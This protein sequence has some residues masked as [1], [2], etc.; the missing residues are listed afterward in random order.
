MEGSY[1]RILLML[2][3]LSTT[4]IFIGC[5]TAVGKAI[6]VGSDSVFNQE[7]PL[8][9]WSSFPSQ[10][11]NTLGERTNLVKIAHFPH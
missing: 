10:F 9:F 7:P 4:I 1:E 5:G 2:G 11:N 8:T 6:G 3:A